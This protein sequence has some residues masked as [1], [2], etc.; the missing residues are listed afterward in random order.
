LFKEGFTWGPIEA[1]HNQEADDVI[2]TQC[3]LYSDDQIV[4]FSRDKD[5]RQLLREGKV[6]ILRKYNLK[7]FGSQWSPPHGDLRVPQWFST[8]DLASEELGW[9]VEP[10]QCVD[11]QA[12]VGD[13]ADGVP[14]ADGIGPKTIGPLLN[15]YK[16]IENILSYAHLT[17]KKKAALQAIMPNLDTVRKVLT[18]N[19]QCA[20]RLDKE[21]VPF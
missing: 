18:L 13:K 8:K 19:H 5:M 16:T 11:F 7:P 21:L 15:R 9:G 14:G 6:I 2:A 10:E 12:V 4:I 20:L 17:P 3:Y 1:A